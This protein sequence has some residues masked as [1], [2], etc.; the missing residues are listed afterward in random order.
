LG[1]EELKPIVDMSRVR[2]DIVKQSKKWISEGQELQKQFFAEHPPVGIDFVD[3]MRRVSI[4]NHRY[5]RG[6]DTKGLVTDDEILYYTKLSRYVSE[7]FAYVDDPIPTDV[8]VTS[9]DANGVSVEWQDCGVPDPDKVI[10]YFH[11]G[12]FISGSARNHRIMTF[13][14]GRLCKTRILS[15]DYR[16][17]PE[18]PFPAQLEDALN[19]Y[20]YLLDNGISPSSIVLMGFSAG[21]AILL[22]LLGKLKETDGD[23]PAG[24]VLKSPATDLSTVT[25]L[26]RKNAALDPSM[27]DGG[28]F[29]FRQAYIADGDPINPLISPVYADM[30]GYPPLLV[31]VGTNEFLYKQCRQLV[32]NAKNVGVEATLQ[33]FPDMVHTWH[34][35]ELPE[36]HDAFEKITEFVEARFSSV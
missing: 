30:S 7:G 18:Y 15:V 11:G 33:E 14:I 36:K 23:F 19:V 21:G 24:A 27:G 31:Q 10:L 29:M 6:E 34:L 3:L 32:V 2:A 13:E 4:G 1:E 5:L 9:V 25:P 22:S 26:T 28:M 17:A 35:L 16:L 12:S 20:T 8:E